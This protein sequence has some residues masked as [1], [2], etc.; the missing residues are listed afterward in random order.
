MLRLSGGSFRLPSREVKA[1]HS[2]VESVASTGKPWLTLKGEQQLANF[3]SSVMFSGWISTTKP[4]E[5]KM[6][7]CVPTTTMER[8]VSK[9][10]TSLSSEL[11]VH[12]EGAAS[13]VH[14]RSTPLRSLSVVRGSR[15]CCLLLQYLSL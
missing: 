12:S 13:P 9:P 7:K 2:L 10:A 4:Q 6:G 8:H 1:Y 3:S 14:P 5:A 15:M 11:S